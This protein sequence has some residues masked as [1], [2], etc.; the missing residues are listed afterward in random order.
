MSPFIKGLLKNNICFF[1]I[2]SPVFISKNYLSVAKQ[3]K[4]MRCHEG[5]THLIVL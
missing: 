2:L 1:S 3:G 4:A 5:F